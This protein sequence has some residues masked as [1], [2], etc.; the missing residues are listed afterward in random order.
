MKRNIIL[1]FLVATISFNVAAQTKKELR[2]SIAVLAKEADMHPDSVD[3]R[4]RKAALNLQLEQ[5]QYA[6]DEYDNVLTRFP[7]N[8]TALYFRA[9]AYE[10]MRRYD[11]AKADY[12]KLLVHIPG[13]FETLVALALLNQKMKR[14]T[15]ALDL[16][17]R[18]V[19]QHADKA[20]AYAVRAGIERE[21]GML[22]LALYD[23]EQAI[24]KD[25]TN[26]EYYIYKVETLIDMKQFD[27][28]MQELNRLTKMGVPRAELAELYKRC[29]RR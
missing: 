11:L 5:W 26:T 9:F 6:K 17:N 15:E 19:N 8:A 23:Y 7:N 21:R 3:L 13:N 28:A 29:K 2:D 18:L 12:E 1:A 10:R 22:Q 4:L 25:N 20:L 27:K 14:H 16:A 24:S